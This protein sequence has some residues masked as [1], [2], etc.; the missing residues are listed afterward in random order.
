[1]L[2][3][4]EQKISSIG[5]VYNLHNL[6]VHIHVFIQEGKCFQE[7]ADVSPSSKKEYRD[8]LTAGPNH[9]L[10]LTV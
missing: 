5:C 6:H 2:L 8:V 10:M 9:P 7:D 4:T 3:M 1:M